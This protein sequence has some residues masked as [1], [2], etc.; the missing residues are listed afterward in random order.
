MDTLSLLRQNQLLFNREA[1]IASIS[2][3]KG[4]HT[5][6]FHAIRNGDIDAFV[7]VDSGLARLHH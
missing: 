7:G 3:C 2:C 4:I 6:S 5:L 1:Q